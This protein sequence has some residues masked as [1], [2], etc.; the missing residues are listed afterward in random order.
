MPCEAGQAGKNE[1]TLAERMGN[2]NGILKALWPM[3]IL[4]P[5]R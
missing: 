3:S 4:R 1:V 2:H 5:G